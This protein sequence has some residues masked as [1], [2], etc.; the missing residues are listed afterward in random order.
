MLRKNKLRSQIRGN[1]GKNCY[2]QTTQI[3]RPFSAYIAGASDPTGEALKNGDSD[4]FDDGIG[5]KDTSV[6][7]MATDV[8]PWCDPRM[9]IFDHV[10]NVGA[11]AVEAIQGDVSPETNNVE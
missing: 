11:E 8:D 3:F 7:S 9:S 10:A 6:E 2:P 5:T 4:M 1:S